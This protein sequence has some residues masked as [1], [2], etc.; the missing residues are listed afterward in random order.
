MLPLREPSILFFFYQEKKNNNSDLIY[1]TKA[2]LSVHTLEI[3]QITDYSEGKKMW[4]VPGSKLNNMLVV[5]FWKTYEASE[6]V[7][8]E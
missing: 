1:L 4:N 2:L 6:A 8:L 5:I 3:M 7:V